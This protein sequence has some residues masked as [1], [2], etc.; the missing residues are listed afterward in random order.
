MTAEGALIDIGAE[1]R[2]LSAS[3]RGREVVVKHR[4]PKRYRHPEIDTS[5]RQTRTRGEARLLALAREA[6]VRT[7]I[8]YDIDIGQCT[9]VMERMEGTPLKEVLETAD[10]RRGDV[11]REVGR[12]VGRLH[13]ADIVHG[14]LTGANL[15][16]RDGT[17]Q[18]ID[19]G[20][21]ERT[22]EVEAKGVDLHVLEEALKAINM[23]ALFTEVEKGYTEVWPEGEEV[24]SRVK[25]I[26]KRGRYN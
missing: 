25:E 23:E 12:S 22:S 15:I 20:L 13:R 18:I 14:D 21:G 19:F 24:V 10:T 26:A 17:V 4:V 9:I 3:W 8:V 5:L 7:P 1:A 6:G 2:I 11:L 16:V